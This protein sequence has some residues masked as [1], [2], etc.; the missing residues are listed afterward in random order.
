M[1]TI[2]Y[3]DGIMAADTLIS[4]EGSGL[5]RG[6]HQKIFRLDDGS[7]IGCCGSSAAIQRFKN[8][9][10]AGADMANKPIFTVDHG[11]GCIWVRPDGTVSC[12]HSEMMEPQHTIPPA[13]GMAMG[14]G[15]EVA[16]G[17]MAAGAD[18]MRAVEIA[19]MIDTGT[20]GSIQVE[21]LDR[22]RRKS[23]VDGDWMVGR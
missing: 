1:T 22:R 4:D 15:N 9:A 2:A 23:S 5:R 18:P 13:W 10:L 16:V 21:S 6:Y 17:A 8:W 3:R 12:W 14:S 11:F 7:I 19:A 20:G